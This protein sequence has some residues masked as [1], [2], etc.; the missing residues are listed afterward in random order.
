MIALSTCEKY[1]FNRCVLN[2]IFITTFKMLN[3]R[4]KSV[5]AN[6]SYVF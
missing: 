5:R 3:I 1:I 6:K 4:S 2:W